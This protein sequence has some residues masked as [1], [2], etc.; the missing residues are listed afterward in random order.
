MS[1]LKNQIIN[2]FPGKMEN[3]DAFLMQFVMELVQK[4]EK[5]PLREDLENCINELVKEGIFREKSG[6]LIYNR[7]NKG[8]TSEEE[9]LIQDFQTSS[10]HAGLSKIQEEIMSMFKGKF[11]NRTALMMNVSVQAATKGFPPPSKEELNEAI[12]DLLGKQILEE[13][14]DILIKKS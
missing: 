9:D 3:K 2:A 4:G 6:L 14:G 12:K 11:E 13:K 5:P 1:S 7:K 8:A 10:G